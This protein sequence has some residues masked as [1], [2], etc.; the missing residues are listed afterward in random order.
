MPDS[1]YED[2]PI[3]K[4]T[5]RF[6][7]DTMAYCE[8]LNAEKKFAL[9][10]QLFRSATSIGANANEAQDAESKADFIHKF[11][12]AAK[13]VR[14]TKYWLALCRDSGVCPNC[15]HL[16]GKLLEIEKVI[17]KIIGTSKGKG[18]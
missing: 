16:T 7:L 15:D 8:L 18:G 12:V 9:A 5:F 6:S 14:E 10:N 1:I 4:L 3:L 2:N 13:E 11:K 17:N